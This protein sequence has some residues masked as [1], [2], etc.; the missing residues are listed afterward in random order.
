MLWKETE[1][2]NCF[3]NTDAFYFQK[4]CLFTSQVAV[5]T[6]VLCFQELGPSPPQDLLGSTY[7]SG[8]HWESVKTVMLSIKYFR[9]TCTDKIISWIFMSNVSQQTLKFTATIRSWLKNA[10]LV[11]V[12]FYG[13]LWLWQDNSKTVF[14]QL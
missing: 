7:C 9:L 14:K 11:L 2:K 1:K 4:T 10:A 13:R 8:K 6:Q 3:C 5:C 12:S